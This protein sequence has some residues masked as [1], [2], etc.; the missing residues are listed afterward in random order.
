[1]KLIFCAS[2]G[3]KVSIAS[4]NNYNYYY[5]ST[6][7]FYCVITVLNHKTVQRFLS[8][9]KCS[10][11]YTGR[12]SSSL[13]FHCDTMTQGEQLTTQLYILIVQ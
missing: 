13:L 1:M 3:G 12:L 10:I 8:N 6:V 7:Q 11:N 9:N 5:K 2:T 4:L